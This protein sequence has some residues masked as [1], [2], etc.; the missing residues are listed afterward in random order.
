MTTEE[1]ETALKLAQREPRAP[2][3]QL[4]AIERETGKR[5]G[6]ETL[7]R[8]LKSARLVWK[9]VRRSLR[10]K[11]SEEAFRAAQQELAEL[12]AKAPYGRCSRMW[13]TDS[14]SFRD[15]TLKPSVLS[16]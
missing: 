1:Q 4:G 8:L 2:H 11:R 9:R 7:K 6:R 12:R 10:H 14:F 5:I 13:L 16:W 15:S 3:Q